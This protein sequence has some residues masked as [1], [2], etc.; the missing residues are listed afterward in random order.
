MRSIYLLFLL[1]H[2]GGLCRAQQYGASISL[3]GFLAPQWNQA[4]NTYNDSRPFLNKDFRDYTNSFHLQLYYAKKTY[5]K[6]TLVSSLGFHR[7]SLGAS[8]PNLDIR[9]HFEHLEVGPILRFRKVA[10]KSEL[11]SYFVDFRPCLQLTRIGVRHNGSPVLRSVDEAISKRV[12][13]FGGGIGLG[14]KAGYSL[15]LT[16]ELLLSPFAELFYTPVL[17]APSSIEVINQT[18][19]NGL[20]DYGSVYAFR[21]GFEVSFCKKAVLKTERPTRRTSKSTSQKKPS[22]GR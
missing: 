10:L 13:S 5:K 19:V 16:E 17:W 14:A 2:V 8:A 12:R 15:Y 3:Q 20:R 11:N 6:V 22:K 21:V 9:L 1:L 4:L 18:S 7:K